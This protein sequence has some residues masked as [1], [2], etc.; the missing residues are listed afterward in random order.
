MK[1]R[2]AMDSHNEQPPPPKSL[3]IYVK[4]MKTFT[5]NV[6]STD[7]VDQ[8]KSKLSAIEGID[9][10]KQEMFFAGMHLKNEDKL[11]DYNI[12][13]NSSVDL[14]VTDAI[15][16]SVR[17]PSVGKT[18]KLNMRKSNSIAD[19]KAEIE[20]EEGILMNEQILMYAG[21]QLEDNQLLSQCDLRNDQTFHVL[22]CPND[23]LHVFIN[24]RGEKTIGLETKRWY[25]VADVKL[26]I[27]NLEGLPACS[28]IL[29][30][31]Q[32][33]VGVA[34]TDGRMLQDQH[35]KNNDTLLL[36]QNVQFFVKS[37]EGKTLTM[38]LKTSDTGKQIKDRIA[39]KLR[40]KESLYYL[41]H[42][43]RVLL[44][45]DTLLD[46]EVESNSTVYIRL[47]NSAVVKP[48][49]KKR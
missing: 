20:Q 41:C 38:V 24:V 1:R 42:K 49:A 47:R 31:M 33:G 35:V 5:L 15:Q 45:E 14:Y 43:G 10:S 13:T 26:M 19:I 39:E 48:N 23:K 4:M 37:W 30:R 40:I 8:I 36:Q 32:S 22:V 17:I 16:I 29:T 44:T 34:L 6:N 25:T 18:T 3:K 28:Q 46:H 27:E 9:K 12:M 7:T 21:Q 11:A 2:P